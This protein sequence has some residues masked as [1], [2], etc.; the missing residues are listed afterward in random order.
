MSELKLAELRLAVA[1]VQL[2]AWKDR[3]ITHVTYAK[4]QIAFWQARVYLH[5]GAVAALAKP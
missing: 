4:E 3:A 1:F 2:W 5:A